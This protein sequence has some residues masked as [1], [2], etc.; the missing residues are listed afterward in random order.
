MFLSKS[1]LSNQFYDQKDAYEKHQVDIMSVAFLMLAIMKAYDMIM[2][3]MMIYWEQ[4][5]HKNHKYSR[6]FFNYEPPEGNPYSYH[7]LHT[8]EYI[9]NPVNWVFF[10]P[11]VGQWNDLAI[12]AG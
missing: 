2:H 9:E 4:A 5:M 7:M 3:L 1:F 11:N 12:V 8:I 6:P 10:M